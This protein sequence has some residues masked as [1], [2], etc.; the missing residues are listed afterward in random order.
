MGYVL[1]LLVFSALYVT[2]ATSLD[3]ML[4]HTGMISLA[5]MAFFALGAYAS[6][7]VTVQLGGD[8][9][10]GIVAGI[11]VAALAS[12]AV[13]LPSARLSGDYF[14]MLTFFFH[15]IVLDLLNNCGKLTGGPAGLPGIPPLRLFGL[16]MGGRIEVA[17]IAVVLG[18]LSVAFY[19]L[20]GNSPFGRILHGIRENELYVQSL[21]RNTVL[22][23]IK[24]CALSCSGAAVAGSIY[25][26]YVSYIDPSSFGV[27]ESILVASMVIVGGPG[28]RFGPLLGALLLVVT[29]EALR[30][31]GLS[32][33]ASANIR[34]VLSG[35]VLILAIMQRSKLSLKGS[36]TEDAN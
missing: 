19:G 3:L 16:P 5:H 6:G 33:F 12:L 15:V 17:C 1:H 35:F 23:K 36:C 21:G 32:G 31:I 11:A 4:G 9:M 14:V 27:L 34:Q 10:V 22:V 7:V 30:M 18:S 25:A 2:L 20:L 26:H 8:G 24:A 29:P 13:S 28:T